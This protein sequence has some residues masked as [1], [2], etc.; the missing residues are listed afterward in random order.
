VKDLENENVKLTSKIDDLECKVKEIS[1]IWNFRMVTAE[2]SM[3]RKVDEA[4]E[5]LRTEARAH[6]KEIEKV[7][8]V[9]RTELG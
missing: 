8:E 1:N 6:Q 3:Q 4:E 2:V 5:A 9:L 7:R